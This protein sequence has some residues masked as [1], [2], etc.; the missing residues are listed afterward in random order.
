MQEKRTKVGQFMYDLADKA[1]KKIMKHKWLI[2]LLNY[3]WGILTTLAGW[4][5]YGF[6]LLFLRGKIGEKG[7]FMHCHYLTIFER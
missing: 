5:M 2:Y 3:T 1:C 6:C 4:V 7:K